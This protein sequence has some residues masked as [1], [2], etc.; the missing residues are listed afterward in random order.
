MLTRTSFALG[1][2][3]FDVRNSQNFRRPVLV[4]AAALMSLPSFLMGVPA[5]RYKPFKL[6]A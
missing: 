4:V 6:F 1:D 2:G 5:D 3:P